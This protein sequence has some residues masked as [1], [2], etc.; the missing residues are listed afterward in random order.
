MHTI[1]TT[2]SKFT[3]AKNERTCN[4]SV[5]TKPSFLPSLYTLYL[6]F[7]SLLFTPRAVFP[8]H[9]HLESHSPLVLPHHLND[10]PSL[11]LSIHCSSFQKTVHY[12]SQ[13]IWSLNYTFLQTAFSEQKISYGKIQINGKMNKLFIQFIYGKKPTYHCYIE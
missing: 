13:L 5:F 11:S 1:N 3:I 6:T 7:W 9:P 12:V 10:T 4:H 8:S 2:L